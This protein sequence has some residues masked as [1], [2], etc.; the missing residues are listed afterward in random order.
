M[1]GPRGTVDSD[2]ATVGSSAGTID[3]IALFII[4]VVTLE[5]AFLG[6]AETAMSI[7]STSAVR[8]GNLQCCEG[9]YGPMSDILYHVR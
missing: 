1:D 8:F 6:T 7:C 9:I 5:A 4:F 3:R 2:S